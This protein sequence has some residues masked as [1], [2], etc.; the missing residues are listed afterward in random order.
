MARCAE[1]GYLAVRNRNTQQL[2]EVGQHY[3]DTGE[4]PKTSTG[5]PAWDS[6]P[7]CTRKA[8]DLAKEMKAFDASSVLEV[9][10]KERN[11]R[12]ATSYMPGYSPRDHYEKEN[13]DRI[14]QLQAEIRERDRQWQ[15]EQRENDRRWQADQ[16]M[17]RRRWQSN[18]NRKLWLLGIVTACIGAFLGAYLRGDKPA[19][20][21][22]S[23]SIEK[24]TPSSE[25]RIE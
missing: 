23:N 4:S 10:S 22:S 13:M 3:R 18:E 25:S 12:N 20:P 8:F 2:E 16:E 6:T 15:Q 24:K 5:F 19:F 1:C 17:Q 14:T 21:P 11:C 9:I 7:M